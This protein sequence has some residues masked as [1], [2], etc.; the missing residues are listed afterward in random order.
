M[1]TPAGIT[2]EDEETAGR[3]TALAHRGDVTRG[4]TYNAI[5][6][7]LAKVA[8]QARWEAEDQLAPVLGEEE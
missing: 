2:V 4:E 8:T 1:T 5:L 6:D 3:I 7:L